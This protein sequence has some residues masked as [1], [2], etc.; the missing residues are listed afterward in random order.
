[1]QADSSGGGGLEEGGI[2]QKGKMTHEHGHQCGD[3]G[4]EGV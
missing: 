1:M 3:C 2:E 4:P